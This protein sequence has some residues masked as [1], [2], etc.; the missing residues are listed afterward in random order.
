MA[1]KRNPNNAALHNHLTE[2]LSM[3][4]AAELLQDPSESSWLNELPAMLSDTQSLKTEIRQHFHQSL[5]REFSDTT[6]NYLYSALAMTVR[7]RLMN[8]LSL[9]HI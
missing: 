5:G 8:C 6:A 2:N 7:N 9:I 4:S 1:Q 3:K